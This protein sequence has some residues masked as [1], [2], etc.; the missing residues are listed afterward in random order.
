MD[1]KLSSLF[2]KHFKETSL[3][4]KGS[5]EEIFDPVLKTT[6]DDMNRLQSQGESTLGPVLSV[7]RFGATCVKLTF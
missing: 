6:Q 4:V 1:K 7:Q 5:F 2:E 3:Q